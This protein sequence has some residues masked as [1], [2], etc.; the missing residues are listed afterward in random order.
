[1]TFTGFDDR[2]YYCQLESKNGSSP[3]MFYS[4]LVVIIPLTCIIGCY[5]AIYLNVKR[6]QKELLSL[7]GS[8]SNAENIRKKIEETNSQ[9][10]KMIMVICS[11]FVICIVPMM[12]LGVIIRTVS[13]ISEA[14]NV[15]RALIVLVDVNFIANPFVYFFM[16]KSYREAFIQLLP[17]KLRNIMI[18]DPSVEKKQDQ[19]SCGNQ[20]QGIEPASSSN[21]MTTQF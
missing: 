9:L 6:G 3:R 19:N 17:T 13:S 1:M 20:T 8:N 21:T 7:L 16:N 18:K 11:C 12:A 2:K 4:I 5:S 15:E 14:A 10:F